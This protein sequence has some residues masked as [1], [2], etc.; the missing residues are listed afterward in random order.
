MGLFC[1]V[2][3]AQV[4]ITIPLTSLSQGSA[5]A[6]QV[7]TWCSPVYCASVYGIGSAFSSSTSLLVN[8]NLGSTMVHVY[9]YDVSGNFFRPKQTVIVNAN[10]IIVLFDVVTSG[11]VVVK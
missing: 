3:W 6:G 5:T 9:L 2:A 8:H 10:Q 7:A 1:A 4:P 11:T